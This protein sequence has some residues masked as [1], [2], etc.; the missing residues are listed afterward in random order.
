MM[1]IILLLK[2]IHLFPLLIFYVTDARAAAF[3]SQA[4]SASALGNAYAGSTTGT[5]D[6]S[7]MYF[8]PAILSLHDRPQLT[9]GAIRTDHVIDAT[10]HSTTINGI[11]QN[12]VSKA[13]P[14][15]IGLIPYYSLS[16]PLNAYWS[17]GLNVSAPFYLN[18]KYGADSLARFHALESRIRSTN[19]NPMLSYKINERLAIG[20]GLQLERLDIEM[21]RNI[22]PHLVFG[23]YGGSHTGYGLNLGLLAQITPELKAGLAYRSAIK[24]HLLGNVDLKTAAGG[25][26]PSY[27]GKVE[28][29]MP[30]MLALGIAWQVQ[31]KM[32]V[33]MDIHWT[34]WSRISEFLIERIAP[35]PGNTNLAVALPFRNS[36]LTAIGL[37]YRL[38]NKWLLQSGL[39]YE[40][41]AITNHYRNP[42]FPVGDRY[43]LSIGAQYS[44][45]QNTRLI[46]SYARQ[47]MK[48]TVSHI[49]ESATTA[50]LQA[51]YKQAVHLIG[52]ALNLTW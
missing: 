33:A 30:E 38:N 8:N 13:S 41:D 26:L 39:S 10:V 36:L 20:A 47:I 45:N 29:T 35:P 5:H 12:G 34:R 7:D 25:N 31:K 50:S 15:Y 37:N 18:T 27:Q 22:A 4:T 44:L 2:S 28:F 11:A 42:R 9:L 14:G 32:E 43:G 46:L 21:S 24:H 1:K 16:L 23:R 49:P 6:N 40:K 17:V 48:N 51:E 19:I 52:A 3:S